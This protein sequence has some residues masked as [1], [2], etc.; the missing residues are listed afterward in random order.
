MY[1][2]ICTVL[3]ELIKNNQTHTTTDLNV[4]WFHKH[5]ILRSFN[6]ITIDYEF[7]YL[8]NVKT[9]LIYFMKNQ[10][11]LLFIDLICAE[12]NTQMMRAIVVQQ[13]IWNKSQ[14]P[15]QQLLSALTLT[16]LLIIYF[17]S[18]YKTICNCEHFN[19]SI[20]IFHKSSH[21]CQGAQHAVDNMPYSLILSTASTQ[22]VYVCLSVAS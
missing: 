22:Y 21:H 9:K 11:H 10:T 6:D 8:T 13:V 19:L 4:D 20:F 7:K 17:L 3:I 16:D 15:Q 12:G 5:K 14:T 18:P 2:V 1:S